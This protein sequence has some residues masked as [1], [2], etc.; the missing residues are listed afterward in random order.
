MQ[1]GNIKK[2]HTVQMAVLFL[3]LPAGMF[4]TTAAVKQDKEC[5]KNLSLLQ[6]TLSDTAGFFIKVHAAENLIRR[7]CTAGIRE[8]FEQLQK[9]SAD[10]E[11]GAAR[12]LARLQQNDPAAYRSSV[13][14]LLDRFR[15]GAA[16]SRL[17]ALESL[18][19]LGYCDR[20]AAVKARADTGTGGFKAMARWVLANSG[21]PAAENR[22]SELLLSHEPVDYRYAAYAL[23][24]KTTVH[25]YTLQRLLGCLGRLEK[26]DAARV[27]VAGCLYVHSTGTRQQAA[28][29]VLITYI[30]GDAAQRYETAEALGIAGNRSDIPLLQTLLVDGNADVRVAAANALLKLMHC[31]CG[32]RKGSM[33]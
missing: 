19:K 9:A 15:N 18:G 21:T 24:F 26:E 33:I 12:V 10:N 25:G 20:S 5:A 28:K 8:Q 30:N 13:E 17:V 7:G 29:A 6:Q 11:I 16:K 1:K 4:L 22:L 31:T 32:G 3:L 2:I 27:Y 14:L 23:R